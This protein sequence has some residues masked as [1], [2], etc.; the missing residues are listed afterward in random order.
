MKIDTWEG[1]WQHF[2]FARKECFSPVMNGR[3]TVA[4]R[5]RAGV[6][7]SERRVSGGTRFQ[8]SSLL[9]GSVWTAGATGPAISPSNHQR[10]ARA[11]PSVVVGVRPRGGG[12]RPALVFDRDMDVLVLL[13]ASGVGG[14]VGCVPPVRCWHTE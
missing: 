12:E 1:T 11:I 2:L 7:F 14:V 9:V 6:I 4:A 3:R 13:G 8:E 5:G 10:P